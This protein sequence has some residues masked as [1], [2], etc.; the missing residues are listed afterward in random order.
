MQEVIKELT[1]SIMRLSEDL[2]SDVK[3]V[4]TLKAYLVE[5]KECMQCYRHTYQT[6]WQAGS[7]F[8]AI[9]GGLLAL[10]IKLGTGPIYLAIAFLVSPFPYYYWF[11]AIY[12]PMNRYGEDRAK[13][14]GRLEL[15]I[16]D[17]DTIKNPGLYAFRKW[18]EEREH[19]PW[20]VSNIVC[21]A[22]A[23]IFIGQ[24]ISILILYQSS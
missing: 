24:L 5:Y 21:I 9:T 11:F 13:I 8:M 22:T 16:N 7:I 12:R 15:K 6:I 23:L 14:L 2:S 17:L 1:T 19:R 3:N 20:R 4:E 10:L 18:D